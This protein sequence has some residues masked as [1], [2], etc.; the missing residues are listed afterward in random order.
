VHPRADPGVLPRRRRLRRRCRWRWVWLRDRPW[1]PR[2]GRLGGA[3]CG[4]RAARASAPATAAGRL[5]PWLTRRT[6]RSPTRKP[7]GNQ[8]RKDNGPGDRSPRPLLI[9]WG[10]AFPRPRMNGSAWGD[11]HQPVR[12]ALG[13]TGSHRSHRPEHANRR[14]SKRL[15]AAGRDALADSHRPA[16]SACV[17]RSFTGKAIP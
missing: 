3:A 6:R 8:G 10:G 13:R 17:A 15:R 5:R 1:G 4:R 12:S 2:P 16:T 9:R 7:S 11:V 14:E